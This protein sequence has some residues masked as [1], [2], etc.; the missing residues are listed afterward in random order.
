MII[1]T[2]NKFTIYRQCDTVDL[3]VTRIT[4][5]LVWIVTFDNMEVY[6]FRETDIK[7]TSKTFR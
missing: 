3:L 4:H 5:K 7:Y 1:D 6:L 2:V